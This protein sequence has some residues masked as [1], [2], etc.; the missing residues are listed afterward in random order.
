LRS[1]PVREAR[2]GSPR[3]SLFGLDLLDPISLLEVHQPVSQA[4]EPLCIAVVPLFP[5]V[6]ANQIKHGGEGAEVVVLLDME[7]EARFVH[8]GSM[9][10]AS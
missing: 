1:A 10:Q 5:Q 7:L 3:I 8:G 2:Y 4:Q 6:L 9:P